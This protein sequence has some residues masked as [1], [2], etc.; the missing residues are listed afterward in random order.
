MSPSHL[1]A[2]P[3]FL[4]T[5]PLLVCFP[6]ISASVIDVSGFASSGTTSQTIVFPLLRS[7]KE[8]HVVAICFGFADCNRRFPVEPDF[9]RKCP[10][11]VACD[12]TMRGF[13]YSGTGS[14]LASR[15]P[16]PC[17]YLCA[18]FSS[19]VAKPKQGSGALAAYSYSTQQQQ[20]V[21]SASQGRSIVIL[22]GS[23][24]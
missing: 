19:S 20:Y 22:L 3:C 15:T 17:L 23:T 7:P 18:L 2:P 4:L 11:H 8:S 10:S 5:H 12:V 21:R 13:R 9:S 6:C 1:L 24:P 16:P 14:L